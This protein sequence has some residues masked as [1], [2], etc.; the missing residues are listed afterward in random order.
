[1]LEKFGFVCASAENA[2]SALE[3][4]HDSTWDLILMDYQ[5]PEMDGIEA[6]RLIFKQSEKSD[7]D[8][9]IVACTANV[10]SEER[11]LCL[12]SGMRDFLK[13]P[14]VAEELKRVLDRWRERKQANG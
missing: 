1:M 4:T 13:K 8:P 6:T 7:F 2:A 3:L 11:R 14:V 5:M 10:S 12:E 9:Y